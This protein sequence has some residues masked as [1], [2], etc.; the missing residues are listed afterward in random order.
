MRIEQKCWNL[1]KDLIL[2]PEIEVNL[3]SLTFFAASFA[4][5]S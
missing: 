5:S 3:K 2:F 1:S 4:T